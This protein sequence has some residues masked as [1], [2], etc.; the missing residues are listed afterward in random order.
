MSIGEEGRYSGDGQIELTWVLPVYKTGQFLKELVERID[1]V[2]GQLGLSHEIIAVVDA[3]P[4]FSARRDEF[5]PSAQSLRVVEL[6]ENRGQDGALLEGLRQSRG[7]WTMIMDA[8]LQDTPEAAVAL[9]SARREDIDIVFAERLGVY[10][11]RSRMFTSKIFRSVFSFLS[12]LPKGACLFALINRRKI[13]PITASRLHNPSIL[14]LFSLYGE[15]FTR[16]QIQRQRRPEGDSA[17]TW[18]HRIRRGLSFIFK[19]LKVKYFSRSSMTSVRASSE[20][21]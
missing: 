15:H 17:Y 9:I 13:G 21:E 6:E 7:A 19:L 14:V 18:M 11:H 20:Y 8:D 10:Q 5:L 2:V 12:G 1:A 4:E 16:V 3:C